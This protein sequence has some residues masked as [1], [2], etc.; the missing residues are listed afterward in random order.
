MAIS[1]FAASR[2][3]QGLP[4]YQSAW[5]QDVVALGAM[6]PIQTV[7][8]VGAAVDFLNIPQGYKDLMVVI[9]GRDLLIPGPNTS[10][11]WGFNGTAVSGDNSWCELFSGGT[12]SS[13]SRATAN[14]LSAGY[15]LG[16][17]AT[18]GIFSSAVFNIMNYSSSTTYKTVLM[19]TAADANGSGFVNFSVGSVKTSTAAVTQLNFRNTFVAGSSLTLYGIKAVGQ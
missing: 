3:T 11:Y 4:K 9:R 6:H 5:D 16:L 15:F 10:I 17:N 18:A 7:Y 19:Q 13:S 14:Q 2:L 12:S 8:P 1:R